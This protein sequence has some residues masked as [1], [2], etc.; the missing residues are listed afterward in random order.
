M[1]SIKSPPAFNPEEGDDYE[2]W[3]SDVN[4]WRLFTKDEEKRLGPAVYLSLKGSARDAVRELEPAELTTGD[5]IKKITDILDRIYLSDE[6]TRAYHAFKEFVEHRRESGTNY[7]NFIIEFEK[8][9]REV[10]RYKLE[11]PPG[12]QAYFLLQAANLPPDLERLARTTAKLE[13]VI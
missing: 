6:S 9:Y 1:S 11:L 8:R 2:S 4:V 7:S 5:G 10:K 13:Y 12:V 3:K